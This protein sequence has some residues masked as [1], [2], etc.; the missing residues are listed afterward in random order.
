MHALRSTT[1]PENIPHDFA[2]SYAPLPLP[3]RADNALQ[4]RNCLRMGAAVGPFRRN[5][6][7]RPPVRHYYDAASPWAKGSHCRSK[8]RQVLPCKKEPRQGRG[9]VRKNLLPCPGGA[10]S[11]QAKLELT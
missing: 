2:A 5:R 11:F 1:C 7:N 4:K 6:T 8:K 3:P 10:K 9:S